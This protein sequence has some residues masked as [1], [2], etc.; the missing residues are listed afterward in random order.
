[1]LRRFD[2]GE[3]VAWASSEN[4]GGPAPPPSAASAAG[5]DDDLVHAAEA[6]R[7]GAP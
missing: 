2:P 7:A 1:V 6:V 5:T 3:R 4:E